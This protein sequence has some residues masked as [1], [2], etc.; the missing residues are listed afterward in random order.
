[1]LSVF[2]PIFE[3][4]KGN[5]KQGKR[6]H[7]QSPY[8]KTHLFSNS[9]TV[10]IVGRFIYFFIIRKFRTEEKEFRFLEEEV[11]V[12]YSCWVLTILWEYLIHHY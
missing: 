5:K 3:K 11:L 7:N 12:H 1:M 9:P 6:N 4:K 2:V 8:K 10:F